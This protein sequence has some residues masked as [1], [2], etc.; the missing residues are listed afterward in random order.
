MSRNALIIAALS[1]MLLA[2]AGCGQK[3]PLYMP[4]DS[5][6]SKTYDPQGDYDENAQQPVSAKQTPG[7]GS[8]DAQQPVSPQASPAPATTQPSAEALP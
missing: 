5:D 6:S 8:T 4:G 3:G 7:Q 1:T 2:L